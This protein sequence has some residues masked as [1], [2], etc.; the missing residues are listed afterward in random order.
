M[1][2]AML[3]PVSCE[4]DPY[5]GSSGGGGVTLD[6]YTPLYSGTSTFLETNMEGITLYETTVKGVFYLNGCFGSDGGLIFLWDKETNLLSVEESYTGLYNETGPVYVVSQK[7]YQSLAGIN[8]LDSVY[9]PSAKT[10]TFNIILEYAD[11]D[12]TIIHG[13][14][15]LI[16]TVKKDL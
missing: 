9:S 7:Q 11:R 15:I 8:A 16:F 12:G 13:P 1:A 3:L 14:T 2:L 4:D 5:E 6:D 10:F